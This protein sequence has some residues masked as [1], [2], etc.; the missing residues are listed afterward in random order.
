MYPLPFG[1]SSPPP[2]IHPSGSSQSSWAEFPVLNSKGHMH[3]NLNFQ[4]WIKTTVLWLFCS[5]KHLETLRN[6]YSD[7]GKDSSWDAWGHWRDCSRTCWG[8]ASYSLWRCLT[9][10]Q[11]LSCWATWEVAATILGSRD[12]ALS[13]WSGSTDSKTLDYQRT[14]L[15]GYQIVRTHT[16]ETTGIQ[17]PAS[18]NHQ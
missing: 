2:P 14:N 8:R 9:G 11:I 4:E 1:P 7:E 5:R 13:L 6:T 16:K 15:R 17:D 3:P 12:Q 10:R 18:P